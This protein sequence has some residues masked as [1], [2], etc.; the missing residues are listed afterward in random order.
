MGLTARARK[1]LIASWLLS[2]ALVG[3]GGGVQMAHAQSSKTVVWTP[4]CEKAKNCNRL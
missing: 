3:S 2:S 4:P 1:V